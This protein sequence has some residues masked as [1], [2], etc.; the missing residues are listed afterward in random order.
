MS[1]KL[2]TSDLKYILS[3]LKKRGYTNIQLCKINESEGKKN[4]R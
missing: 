1:D 2:N 4:D 3:E